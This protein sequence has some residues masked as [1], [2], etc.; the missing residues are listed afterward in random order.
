MKISKVL[1]AFA[2]SMVSGYLAT[3]AMEKVSMK[4]YKLESKKD[5]EKEEEVR[6]GPPFQIAAKK[7]LKSLGFELNEDQEKKMGQVFHF[8]LGMGWAGLYPILKYT[9][10][11][12]TTSN[13]LITGASLSLIVDEGITPVLGYSAPNKKYPTS[14]HIRGFL[15]HLVYGV[16]VAANYEGISGIIGKISEKQ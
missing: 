1:F 7:T 15:A 13:G 2:G 3:K 5:Q 4:L 11:L 12:S 8:G 9:N 10:S 16:A 14:T 6:P